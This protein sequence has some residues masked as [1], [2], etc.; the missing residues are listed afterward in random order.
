MFPH[1]YSA[2]DL[3]HCI[4]VEALFLDENKVPTPIIG[5]PK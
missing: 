5:W 4:H 1:L 3:K 2:L